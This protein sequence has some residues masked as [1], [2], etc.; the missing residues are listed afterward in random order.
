MKSKL[1]L[2]IRLFFLF[3]FMLTA[4]YSYSQSM[5]DEETKLY[6]IMME[7]RKDKGLPVIPVSKSLTMVAQTHVKD[8]Q[9][10]KPDQGRCNAHSWSSKGKWSSC[11]YTPDHAQAKCMWSKPGELTSY[12]GNGYEIAFGS[13]NARY[14]GYVLTAEDALKGWQGSPGHNAVIVNSGIWKDLHWNAIGVG[15]YG[16]FAV[17][18]FGAEEDK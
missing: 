2:M 3:L 1:S 17:V 7:Y 15:I 18:W 9:N 8:L 12:S 10:N 13:S 11:C 14:N 4:G 6:N 16:G 5:T